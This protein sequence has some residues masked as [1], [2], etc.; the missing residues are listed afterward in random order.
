MT[1]DPH[2]EHGEVLRRALNAEA[3][4]V[5]PSADGLERIRARIEERRQRRFGW[6]WFTANWG[7]PV[8]AVGAAVA[9]AGIGV[10]APQTLHI[11][12]TGGNGDSGHGHHSPEGA[13]GAQSV[14]PGTQPP[15]PPGP[16]S[17]SVPTYPSSPTS[18]S[19]S[20]SPT[21]PPPAGASPTTRTSPQPGTKGGKPKKACPTPSPTV[22]PTPQPTVAPPSPTPQPSV[23]P[24]PEPSGTPVGSGEANNS[25]L[26]TT[27][28]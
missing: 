2:D 19:P 7:R 28:P 13:D 26:T 15:V 14:V 9:I 3:G 27:T 12:Q 10:S 4:E 18:A 25:N 21:C 16:G 11:I 1:T 22:T 5:I 17:T 20:G 23:T 8:L 6:A 24:T